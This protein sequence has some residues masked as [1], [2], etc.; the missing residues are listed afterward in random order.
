VTHMP[1]RLR[2]LLLAGT[3]LGVAPSLAGCVVAAAGAGVAGGYSILAQE[4]S[5]EQQVRDASI[6]A[7]VKQSWGN[8]NQAVA[9]DLTATVYDGRVLIT[10]RVPQEEWRAEAVKRAWQAE[11]VKEVYNEIEV[12]ADTHFMDEARDTLIST[13]LRNDL[14]FD[15]HIKSI[16]YTVNTAAGVVYI[17]GSARGQRELD[18]VTDY[19]RNTRNVRRVVSY[20]RIRTGEP[21]TAQAS[22]APP[23]APVSAGEDTP[24]NAPTPR[25]GVEVTPLK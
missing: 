21:A 1:S 17:I 12:G 22:S 4:L 16:N 20:V 8:Y 25:A 11:G 13:Q 6:K 2:A 14:R 9:S 15:T 3:L 10:G 24:P 19:A 23:P 7:V 5:P 18:R